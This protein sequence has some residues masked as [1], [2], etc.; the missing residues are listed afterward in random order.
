MLGARV[1]E[2]EIEEEGKVFRVL[3]LEMN[4]AYLVFLSERESQLGTLAV[5]LPQLQ[6]LVD[7]SISSVLLG[8][9]NTV[10]A[11]VFAEQFAQKTKKIALVSVFT[12]TVNER[13]AGTIFMKL[14]KIL[15]ESSEDKTK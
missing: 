9:R 12:R 7:A 5:A 3:G 8:D 1:V 14:V 2:K 6:E 11:R 10:L 4:N 15:T 13:E